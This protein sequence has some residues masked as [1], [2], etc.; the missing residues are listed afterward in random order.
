[1]GHEAVDKEGNLVILRSV[2][3][4][5]VRWVEPTRASMFGRISLDNAVDRIHHIMAENEDLRLRVAELE[6]ELARVM[7]EDDDEP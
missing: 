1:M 4:E 5:K 6:A 7:G 3:E 2:E